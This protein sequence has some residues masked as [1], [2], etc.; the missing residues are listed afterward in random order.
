MTVAG[1]GWG[2]P[3]KI[4][5]RAGP[6]EHER[7]L[8]SAKADMKGV[9]CFIHL[10]PA[11]LLLG[12]LLIGLRFDRL[13]GVGLLEGARKS[14]RIPISSTSGWQLDAAP[15]SSALIPIARLI[16]CLTRCTRWAC[17][18]NL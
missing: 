3:T 4:G 9:A 16:R 15:G 5:A 18:S 8:I 17:F 2:T 11:A 1:K 10:W 12:V 13:V 14:K 6:N 7:L